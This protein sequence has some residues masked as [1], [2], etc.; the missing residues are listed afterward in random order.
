MKL[1]H[2]P[3]K[4]CLD[5]GVALPALVITAPLQL[6]TAVAVRIAMGGPV[7]F[8][9]ERPGLNGR[10]F[11]LMKF[12]SMR[13][14]DPSRGWTDDDDDESP[15]LTK[16]GN[17]I[18]ATSLDELPTLW[19]VLRGDMSLVGPRPLL[20][21]YLDRYTPEQARRHSVKPGLTGL[22]QVSGRNT[23]SWEERFA[24]DVE[25]ADN[26]SLL[27]DLKILFRTFLI[28]FKRDG[29]SEEG[30]PTM[31]EF[32]GAAVVTEPVTTTI[33]ENSDQVN[34]AART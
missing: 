29:I 31:S 1:N 5:I 16:V 27:L 4:R 10:P 20:M 13:P 28:V 6:A 2:S 32:K 9:Q 19:N 12:R 22:A 15:R 11:T 33:Q 8:R 24:L 26:Q 17:F 14:I 21:Q 34:E 7:I 30:L 18:R 25:Y 3:A 23:L